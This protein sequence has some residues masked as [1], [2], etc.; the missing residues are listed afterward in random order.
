MDESVLAGRPGDGAASPLMRAGKSGA[1]RTT[2]STLRVVSTHWRSVR[3]L[4]SLLISRRQ[5]MV[6]NVSSP[7]DTPST[8]KASQAW[9]MGSCACS[10]CQ[11]SWIENRPPTLNSISATMKLQK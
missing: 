5:P 11:P 10:L 9:R 4:R 3:P 1:H 2:S 7:I 6:E 8:S